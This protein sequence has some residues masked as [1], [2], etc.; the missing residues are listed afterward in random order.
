MTTL[1]RGF[2]LV[3]TIFATLFIGVT[4]LAIVN[5]FPGAYLS[6]RRSETSVQ[7][8]ML[9]K[10]ILDEWR[11]VSFE[12]LTQ[13]VYPLVPTPNGFDET[14]LE[15]RTIE[16]VTYSAKTNIYDIPGTDSTF[17]KGARVTVQYRLGPSL[18]EVVHETYLHRLIR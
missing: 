4:V 10:S 2:T 7:A 1:H 14:L 15:S 17:L 9:A 16:G 11:L 6:I 13:G 3:E 5:L 18:K 12:N 8:D